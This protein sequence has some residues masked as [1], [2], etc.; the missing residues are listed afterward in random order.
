[1]YRKQNIK[2]RNRQQIFE[3]KYFVKENTSNMKDR[4]IQREI[5]RK[6]NYIRSDLVESFLSGLS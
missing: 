4:K 2:I 3:K 1:M 6:V 5:F